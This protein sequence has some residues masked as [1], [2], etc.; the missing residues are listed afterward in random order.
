MATQRHTGLVS[1]IFWRKAFSAVGLILGLPLHGAL[2]TIEQVSEPVGFLSKTTV[3]ETG[4][5]LTTEKVE[6]TKNGYFFSYWTKGGTRLADTAGRSLTQT[7]VEVDAS[8]TLTAHYILQTEDS[9][10]DGILDWF[11]YRN[12]GNLAGVISS[13]PDGDGYSNGQEQALG[14]DPTISDLVEDGGISS[15]RSI[16]FVFADKSLVRYEIKSEPIGFVN[17]ASGFAEVNATIVTPN[18]NGATNGYLFAYWSV[19]GAR[20]S[21]ATGKALSQLDHKLTASA[22][23]VAHY[24]PAQEDSDSDGLLDSSELNQFGDLSQEAD[25]DADSDGFANQKEDAL[26]Q[27]STVR[28]FVEDGG[29]S[30]RHSGNFVFGDFN[31][32]HYEIK[33]EPVGFIN[34]SSGYVQPNTIVTTPS[35]NGET[36]GYQFTYWSVN[37]SRQASPNGTS[38][39]KLDHTLVTSSI[40]IAHYVKST[41]DA[42]SDGMM[43]W[44]E[45]RQ[46]GQLVQD[47]SDD[48]D[49]DNY[50]NAQE[51]SAGQEALIKDLIED[52]GI[53][54]RHSTNFTYFVQGNRTPN[55]ATLS[56][57]VFFA[58]QPS[59]LLVG[60]LQPIDYDDPNQQDAYTY[61]FVEGT[62]STDNGQ[63][64]LVGNKLLTGTLMTEGNY[65]I[66]IRITDSSLA[67]A[68]TV[69]Q[70]KAFL[71]GDSDNDGDGLTLD[72]ERIHSTNPNV[73]DTDGDGYSDLIEVN[74]G[75]DPNDR[76]S[77]PNKAPHE[78]QLSDNRI[79]ENQPT[80]ISIGTL[81][82][83]DEDANDTHSFTFV[84]GNG[85]QHNNLFSI[86]ANGT[87]RT[88]ATF[89]YETNST[90]LHIRVKATDEHN[91]SLAKA[92]SINITNVVE[93]LDGDGIEDH[94]DPDDDGDGFSDAVEIAYGSDPRDA[95]SLVNQ[96]PTQ[97]DLN[98]SSIAENSNVGSIVGNLNATD[99]DANDTHSYTFVDGNGS[100]HN[101]L[102]SIDANGTLKTSAVLDFETSSVLS[103]RVKATDPSNESIEKAF[104]IRVL[105][106]SIPITDT[107]QW[108]QSEGDTYQFSGKVLYD[109]EANVTG[110]GFE[111]DVSLQFH[112]PQVLVGFINSE[113]QNF[114]ASAVL[115]EKGQSFYYRAFA[116]N[117]EGTGY[118]S[119]KRFSTT[120]PLVGWWAHA[121]EDSNGW[122]NSSWF[123]IFLP[124]D[125]G[126][127]YHE[128]WGWI[129][130]QDDNHGGLWLWSE[131]LGWLWTG[132]DLFPYL[133]RNHDQAWIYFLK[134][135]NGIP[136]FYNHAT[137]QVE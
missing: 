131:P 78:L 51:A 49:L 74:F 112:N 84:D 43:D 106:E 123:G 39:S 48:A 41:E 114:S 76:N 11:E 44:L 20:Q 129:F 6:L 46:F 95:N 3:V 1:N 63:F 22:N 97:L 33:S 102:F 47:S 29:I 55:G 104:S 5:S 70:L 32:V 116:T 83:L 61:E 35:L 30:S 16:G 134:S 93:D 24:F 4:A 13:D 40:I 127:L 50:T 77:L 98:G 31:L 58:E 113:T 10:E 108:E 117:I 101:S 2:V 103:I 25:A 124:F 85:S 92:F 67:F 53:S 64:N 12:F 87:L 54:S 81:S 9:D 19:N 130:A 135:K 62:G 133:Y 86:D 99:P 118:G 60:T 94:A 90:A 56:N 88:N 132:E 109:G 126:W 89:D 100:T 36:N 136:R 27:E 75:S 57:D 69:F 79:L 80:G 8:F 7:T 26:G 73:A 72:Q 107:M 65:S 128:E 71:H 119:P 45:L 137:K 52:G 15:R 37:G 38:L 59:G 34:K 96:A 125:N 122:R 21:G 23:I 17:T 18:L 91:A 66:R 110:Y 28:D 68:E 120:S 42:D 105:D 121:P 14:Q 115:P 82:A 111:L